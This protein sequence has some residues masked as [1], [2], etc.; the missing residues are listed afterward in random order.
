MQVS[1]DCLVSCLGLLT[2]STHNK[3]IICVFVRAFS[4]S[5][6]S[7]W[8]LSSQSPYRRQRKPV[9]IFSKQGTV[10]WF[11]LHNYQ[12]TSVEV[13]AYLYSYHVTIQ[14][15]TLPPVSWTHHFITSFTLQFTYFK[16]A[17]TDC[18]YWS[19]EQSGWLV[20]TVFTPIL[21]QVYPCAPQAVPGT[22]A[23]MVG[24]SFD[25]STVT[26][27][28]ARVA[29]TLHQWRNQSFM[30]CYIHTWKKKEIVSFFV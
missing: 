18:K 17:L 10:E 16:P 26:W 23:W 25:R 7:P 11:N 2:L 9:G 14:C 15:P 29:Q 4:S 22:A 30:I 5:V 21:L 8:F 1:K 13:F 6:L 19:P 27:P 3:T 20:L 24:Q 12:K 28:V